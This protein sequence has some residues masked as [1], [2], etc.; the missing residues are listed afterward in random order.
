MDIT[1]AL[2][3]PNVPARIQAATPPASIPEHVL[4]HIAYAAKQG[5]TGDHVRCTA[6][7]VPGQGNPSPRLDRICALVAAP[8]TPAQ[9]APP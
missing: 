7:A 5:H 1:A 3:G 4:R 9:V 2:A 8:L 6:E